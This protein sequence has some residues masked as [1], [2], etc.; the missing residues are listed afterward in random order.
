MI[1]EKLML[2]IQLH[3]ERGKT[4]VI[5]SWFLKPED[6]QT[7]RNSFKTILVLAYAP[8]PKLLERL[9]QRNTMAMLKKD[10]FLAC[11]ASVRKTLLIQKAD[12]CTFSR[13]EITREELDTLQNEFL[14]KFNDNDE[15]TIAPDQAYDFVINTGENQKPEYY[16]LK[17]KQQIEN[18]KS[19][20]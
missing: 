15:I 19:L 16:A 14:E 11:L 9:E 2:E 7:C 13:R 18:L 6:F 12:P 20:Q 4:V 10:T 8:L 1:H 5:D 17:I 3:A